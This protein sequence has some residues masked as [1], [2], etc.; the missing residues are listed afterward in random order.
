LNRRHEDTRAG[1]GRFAFAVLVG[2]PCI[3]LG[4]AG[5][6]AFSRAPASPRSSSHP[7]QAPEDP[8]PERTRIVAVGP[9]TARLDDDEKM[10]LRALIREEFA[11][12]KAAAEARGDAGSGDPPLDH[13]ISGEQLKSYDHARTLVDDGLARGVWTEDD[14]A[15]LRDTIAGLPTEQRFE[16]LRPLV[17]AVNSRKVH[18]EGRGPLF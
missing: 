13:A 2:A 5:G 8:S 7:A 14:R 11:A 12:Q 4:V 16:I 15:Q 17:V 3:V 9:S 18:F 10:A 1:R 6:I